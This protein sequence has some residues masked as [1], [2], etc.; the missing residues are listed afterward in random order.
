[1]DKLHRTVF[2]IVRHQAGWA[3]EHDGEIFDA[4]RLR[5]EALAAA[6]R[7]ARDSTEQGRPA[8]ICMQGESRF[9]FG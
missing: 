7:R 4:S 6:S 2:T 3:V 5:E 9:D 1:L 8:R